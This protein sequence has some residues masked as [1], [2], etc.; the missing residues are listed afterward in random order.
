[1]KKSPAGTCTSF[2]PIELAWTSGIRR[3]CSAMTGEPTATNHKTTSSRVDRRR[4]LF[5]ILLKFGITS[6]FVKLPGKTDRHRRIEV[7]LLW[8][9]L[10]C[11]G[12]PCGRRYAGETVNIHRRPGLAAA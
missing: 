6:Q 10:I 8:A 7:G 1:M 4:S 12:P 3:G 2:R 9:V 5:A 11:I